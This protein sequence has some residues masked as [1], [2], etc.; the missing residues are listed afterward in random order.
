MAHRAQ[1]RPQVSP[2]ALP[3]PLTVAEAAE[4]ARVHRR[5]VHRWIDEGRFESSRPIARGS[6]RRLIERS[7]F[8][9]FLGLVVSS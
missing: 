5:T 8:M 3:S 9:L 7:S 2:T 6:S 4:L 1:Q